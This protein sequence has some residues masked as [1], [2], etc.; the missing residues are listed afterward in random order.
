[1]KNMELEVRKTTDFEIVCVPEGVYEAT[2]KEIKETKPYINED[3]SEVPRFAIIFEFVHENE[4]KTLAMVVSQIMS[5]LS[6]LGKLY[7]KLV[8]PL[9]DMSSVDTDELL[10]KQCQI[11]VE[12]YK[13][14]DGKERSAVNKVLKVK[15]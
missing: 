13:D 15:A 5:Q 6:N 9:G 10:D 3:G 11:V 8:K 14:K 7:E 12:N 1:M 4:E 2:L